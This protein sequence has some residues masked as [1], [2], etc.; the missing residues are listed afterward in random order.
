MVLSIGTPIVRGI[1]DG[2]E[3]PDCS[4]VIPYDDPERAVLIPA[5]KDG[6]I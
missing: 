6:V 4:R 2:T 1:L 3:V 5:V